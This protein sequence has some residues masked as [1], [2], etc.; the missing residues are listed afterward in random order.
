MGTYL[1]GYFRREN[2]KLARQ[3]S[4]HT[5]WRA[6]VSDAGCPITRIAPKLFERIG[7]LSFQVCKPGCRLLP[8]S[9]DQRAHQI[10]FGREM[11]MDTWLADTDNVRNVGVAEAVV[12]T[13]YDQA[14]R[15]SKDVVCSGG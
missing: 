8:I 2:R 1:K 14:T 6:G 15:A 9:G 10:R 12:A 3:K 13:G 5:E 7:S 11:V 4:A